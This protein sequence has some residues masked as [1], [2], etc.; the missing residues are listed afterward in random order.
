MNI[1][2]YSTVFM[3]CAMMLLLSG[4]TKNRVSVVNTSSGV[5]IHASDYNTPKTNDK[6]IQTT[7]TAKSTGSVIRLGDGYEKIDFPPKGRL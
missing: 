1:V 3:I 4:C 6:M 2:R 7:P 5:V